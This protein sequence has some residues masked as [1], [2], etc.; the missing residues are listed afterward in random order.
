PWLYRRVPHPVVLVGRLVEALD[1]WWNIGA[2]P[3]RRLVG[4]AATIVVVGVAGAIGWLIAVAARSLPYCW[5]LE[6]LLMGSLLAQ[7]SLYRH[8]GDVADG[9]EKG[10]L[11]AGRAAVSRIVGRDPQSLDGAGVSRA[12][13]ESLAENFS[14]GVFAPLFWGLLLGLPGML[15]YKA[16][17]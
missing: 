8:V 17:N 7:H 12:A 14:D 9:L 3:R 15:A 6:A 4:I 11:A 10:G 2:G 5:I 13:L 1:R 16:I